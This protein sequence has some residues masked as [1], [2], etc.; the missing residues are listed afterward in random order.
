MNPAELT[1]LQPYL[2]HLR[3]LPFV[4]GIRVEKAKQRA[5]LYGVDAL[6]HLRTLIGER[7]LRAE[8][9]RT[10]L[11]RPL[12]D[13]FLARVRPFAKVRWILLAPYVG[14]EIARYLRENNMNYLDAAGNCCLAIDQNYLVLVEGRRPMRKAPTERG[15]RGPGHQV[16]FAILARPDLLNAPVRT[17]AQAAGIGKTAA[18]DMLVRLE[19]EGLVGTDREG[20]RLLQPKIALDRWLAGYNALVR[21]KLLVG[22]FRTNDPRV[23]ALEERIEHELGDTVQWAWGGGAAAMRLTG[24]YRGTDTLVHIAHVVRDFGKRLKAIPAEGGPLIVLRVPG[25]V[26]FEGIKPRTVHPLLVYTELLFA[27]TERDRAAA[28]EIAHQFLSWRER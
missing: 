16:L 13:A 11:T 9:K 22:R 2:T 27:G 21:P 8:I 5:D 15:V 28:E 3:G 26:A 17:L 7:E 14:T 4:R 18:A 1:E 19:S 24:Y 20:R 23:G 12:A 6:V 25:R 10:H